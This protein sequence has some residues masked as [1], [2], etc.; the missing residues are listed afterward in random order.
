MPLVS[1]G[2]FHHF[3]APILRPHFADRVVE[4]FPNIFPAGSFE[5]N[6][7]RLQ[8]VNIEWEFPGTA[9]FPCL[10]KIISFGVWLNA[11][12]AFFIPNLESFVHGNCC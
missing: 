10:L 8:W 1:P 6:P 3:V 5:L 9:G 2:V 4:L 11:N 12:F 7:N